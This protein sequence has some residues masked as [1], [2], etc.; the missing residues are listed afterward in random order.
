MSA[1]I[2]ENSIELHSRSFADVP[3]IVRDWTIEQVYLRL[4]LKPLSYFKSK[5]E[6]TV[7]QTEL[8]FSQKLRTHVS[9]SLSHVHSCILIRF[10]YECTIVHP[11]VLTLD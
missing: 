10:M 3:A 9:N 11:V 8:E 6:L 4:L 7:V 5:I 1:F 2:E